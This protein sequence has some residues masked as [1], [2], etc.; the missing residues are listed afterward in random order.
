MD[1]STCEECNANEAGLVAGECTQCGAGQEP[2]NA[3]TECVSCGA[4]TAGVG[5][6]CSQC[7]DGTEPD[8]S[9]QERRWIIEH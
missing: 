1:R 4:G 2:N 7:G 6:I 5:G 8:G 3:R 9:E